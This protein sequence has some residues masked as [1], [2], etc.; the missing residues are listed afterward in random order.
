MK[1]I[2]T[3]LQEH[4]LDRFEIEELLRRNEKIAAIKLVRD[5]TNWDLRNS[6]DFVEAF[7]AND[8]HFT[9]DDSFSGNSN[10][11]VKTFNKNGQLTVKL[12]LNNQPEKVVFPSDPD[13][14]E[15]KKVMGNKPE[16]LAYEKEYLENPTK[17]QNQKNTLFIEE[18]GSGKWKVVLLAAVCTIVIIYLIYSNS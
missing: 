15:V 3:L 14:A 4:N 16:L 10:V 1:D 7:E 8:T 18:N 17:F 13:W 2:D 6:K 11:S 9:Q 12:K 5:K